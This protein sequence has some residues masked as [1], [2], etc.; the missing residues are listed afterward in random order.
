MVKNPRANAGD[1]G[2]IPDPKRSHMPRGNQAR[3]PQVLNL[4]L[5]SWS[6]NC[7]AQVLQLVCSRAGALQQEKPLQW[8]AHTPQLES[9]PLLTAARKKPMQP[10]RPSSDKNLKNY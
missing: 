3:T 9:S 5:E 1:M 7:W 4:F 8:E 6:P 10:Q 2:S